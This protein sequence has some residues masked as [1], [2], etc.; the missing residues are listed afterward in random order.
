MLIKFLDLDQSL[1][2]FL[3]KIRNDVLSRLP[4]YM[5]PSVF[6]PIASMPETISKKAD[7]KALRSLGSAKTL[8]E[9]AAYN[10]I[11]RSHR[12]PTT[13]M[14]KLLQILLIHTLNLKTSEISMN[15]SFFVLGGDSIKAMLL[16]AAARKVGFSISVNDIF[17]TSKLSELVLTMREIEDT[18]TISI[19]P[20]SII[21]TAEAN[22]VALAQIKNAG[23]S[24]KDVEDYYP[25][26]AE[27][28]RVFRQ[29]LT[30]PKSHIMVF[31][32]KLGPEID[33]ETLRQA[34]DRVVEVHPVLRTRILSFGD[35]ASLQV[36]MKETIQW[37]D[38]DGGIESAKPLL[39][40]FGTPLA[41][42]SITKSKVDGEDRFFVF[43]IHH[44]LIDGWSFA[45]LWNAVAYAYE[46]S[47]ALSIPASFNALIKYYESRDQ[48]ATENFWR[49]E[50]ANAHATTLLTWPSKAYT[51][52][53]THRMET[54]VLLPNKIV[55]SNITMCTILEVSFA[56]TLS[57]YERSNDITFRTTGT[58][59]TQPVASLLEILGAVLTSFPVRIQLNHTESLTTLLNRVQTHSLQTSPYEYLGIENISNLT[60]N[61]NGIVCDSNSP[62]LIIQPEDIGSCKEGLEGMTKLPM[63]WV[64]SQTPL[65]VCC[66]L[67]DG[68]TKMKIATGFDRNMIEEKV[69]RCGILP[70]FEA[71]VKEILR[72]L[73]GG[74]GDVKVGG[75]MNAGVGRGLKR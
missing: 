19:E 13:A 52:Y 34:W 37:Q 4:K 74:E 9:I 57:S 11:E 65:S 15:D 20:F 63:E 71:V 41:S 8:H 68:G 28:D 62:Y 56:I 48:A 61:T 24:D 75:L 53:Q 49:S 64:P 39:V 27:Q 7:R 33:S 29:T 73:S 42:W 5:I 25:T 1:L 16:V 17:A 40:G 31:P 60:D 21:K 23:I 12:D 43:T 35:S 26:T 3:E 66:I 36:V 6:I 54:Q 47:K 32:F 44:A 38:L 59:R 18:S 51:P 45:L 70:R 72:S 46:H 50:L 2:P 69:V 67:K 55:N 30:K 22:R 14:D 10:G 58:G